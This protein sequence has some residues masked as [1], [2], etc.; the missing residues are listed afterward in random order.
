ML[1]ASSTLR[2]SKKQLV[3]DYII[4]VGGIPTPLKNMKVSWDDDIFPINMESHN[5][6]MFQ[7][8]NQINI[9]TYCGWLRNPASPC[10]PFHIYIYCVK[11]QSTVV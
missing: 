7:T 9:V 6:F 2:Y 10:I 4:L 3:D 1:S 11:W 5:P 8:T